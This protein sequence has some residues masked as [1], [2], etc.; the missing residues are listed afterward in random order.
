MRQNHERT[1]SRLN[2]SI[3]WLLALLGPLLTACGGMDSSPS[4]RSV[5]LYL[6]LEPELTPYGVIGE[7]IL[8][9]LRIELEG[10]YVIESTKTAGSLSALLGVD[11]KPRSLGIVQSD[12]LHHYIHGHHPNFPTPRTRSTVRAL[13]RLFPE[14]VSL[15]VPEDLEDRNFLDAQLVC[16]KRPGTGTLVTAINL[17]NVLEASWKRLHYCDSWGPEGHLAPLESRDSSDL[18][19]R[20]GTQVG[21][22]VPSRHVAKP[23][24]VIETMSSSPWFKQTCGGSAQYRAVFMGRAEAD[25]LAN[26]F[27]GAYSPVRGE[28]PWFESLLPEQPIQVSGGQAP[29]TVAVDAILVGSRDLPEAVVQALQKILIELDRAWKNHPLDLSCETPGY[30]VYCGALAPG[31]KIDVGH[32]RMRT[33]YG[34]YEHRLLNKSQ[35]DDIGE[36]ERED[37][38]R[39]NGFERLP[40]AMHHFT[41]VQ[42]LDRISAGLVEVFPPALV[43]YFFAVPLLVYVVIFLAGQWRE[44]R[45]VRDVVARVWGQLQTSRRIMLVVGS[46]LAA[47]LIIAI[48]VWLCE[49]YEEANVA[50]G[51]LTARGVGGA[52]TWLIGHLIGVDTELALASRFSLVWLGLLKMGYAVSSVTLVYGAASEVAS[53]IGGRNVKDIVVVIGK[54]DSWESVKMELRSVGRAYVTLED[55]CAELL[56]AS[57]GTALGVVHPDGRTSKADA[58][59][60]RRAVGALIVLS[61]RALAKRARVAGV[62]LWVA[63][64]VESLGEWR[65]TN[66]PGVALVAEV[67]SPASIPLVKRLGATR[68]ICVERFGAELIVQSVKNPQVISFFEELVKTTENS[69]ELY[70]DELSLGPAAEESVTF[71]EVARLFAQ[72]DSAGGPGR[73][74]PV[75]LVRRDTGRVLVNPVGADATIYPGDRIMVIAR[76]EE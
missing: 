19:L 21:G 39:H 30:E 68:V 9:S 55:V 65:R 11:S 45:S 47:H 44:L 25:I 40:V 24:L 43:R 41:R 23:D 76:S 6:R 62:D 12:V 37:R 72:K 69:N 50:G 16:G 29:A 38:L 5:T 52:L 75:G 64:T 57:S 35:W 56:D 51:G 28:E 58:G 8:Q 20:A 14:L 71:D 10:E 59:V 42:K 3:L 27:P 33:A 70:F 36:S 49:Y 74:V 53:W 54:G 60:V 46:F 17:R 67:R 13:V 73:R 48:V 32:V 1:R 15:Q 18:A 22:E 4:S 26:A 66:R 31:D 7:Y 63:Q 2:W 34:A 61:D